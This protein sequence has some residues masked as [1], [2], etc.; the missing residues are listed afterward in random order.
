MSYSKQSKVFAFVL[1][2]IT[3]GLTEWAFRFFTN[4]KPIDSFLRLLILVM[5]VG[6]VILVLAFAV[7][8]LKFNDRAKQLINKAP[9]ASLIYVGLFISYCMVLAVEFSCR[10]YFKHV[11]QAPYTEQTFWEPSAVIKDSILGSSLP[12]DTVIS[13]AY[14]ANDTLIYKQNYKTDE[15]GRRIT[16]SST[17]DS[18]TTQFAMIT[19]C[20]FAFGYGL[21]ERQTLSYYL[22]SLSAYRGYNY[23]ISG[24]GT[25]Q[26]LAL[27]QNRLLYSEIQQS[28]GVLIHLF[29]D[30]HIPRLIGS[31]RLIKLWA[32]NYPYYF[33]DDG[34][35]KRGGSFWSGRNLLSRFYKVISQSAFIDLF[36]IDFPW[37]VSP[38]HL[39]L[40]GAVVHGAQTEFL[41]QYPDGRF[42]VIIAPNSRLA[43]R[44]SNVLANS[45]IE[46]LDLSELLDKEEPRYKIHWTEGHPNN[47]YYLQIAQEINGY[48]SE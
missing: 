26:T 34:G 43:P 41:K 40:F 8:N 42:L 5:D 20:S 11:Y 2:L 19:G 44:I 6:A 3:L 14:F 7:S 32:T 17:N 31:R 38:S 15:F 24:H 47:K 48:L 9:R 46:Y 22:D 4:S 18:S 25:Q 45:N 37:Y 39:E 27:L 35:L 30:D 12:K 29:I 21:N 28:N 36:D 13:H 23:G 1:F 33:L 16:P 10:F